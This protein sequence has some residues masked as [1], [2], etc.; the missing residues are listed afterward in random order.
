MAIQNYNF[1]LLSDMMLMVRRDIAL[2]DKTLANP[3]NAVALV[4]GEWM[5]L[6]SNGKLVRAITITDAA[7]TVSAH[8]LNWPLWAE[9]GRYDM[10][11]NSLGK[12]P[13]IKG[14]YFEADT[15]VFDASLGS[16]IDAIDQ[17]LKVAVVEIDSRKY[18]GLMRHAGL[19]DDAAV[20]AY[21]E[22]L[23]ANNGG[24]LRIVSGVRT[25]GAS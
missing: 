13:V 21:V 18:S 16:G 12:A 25:F 5:A 17:P 24:K 11:A 7:G 19:A 15:R 14:G 20:V 8:N 1:E 10:Q 3:L 6:D 9:R 22:K 4:D 2:A 23:P